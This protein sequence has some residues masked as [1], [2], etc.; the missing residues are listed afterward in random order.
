MKASVIIPALNEAQTIADVVK[1]AKAAPG[2]REVIVVSDGSR[3]GTGVAAQRAGADVV[4]ELP[5]R[6]GKG[7]AVMTGVDRARGEVVIMLDGD[8]IGLQPQH[9]E[10]LLDPLLRDGTDM[11]VGVFRRDLMQAVLPLYSGQR[12]VRRDLLLRQPGLRNVGFGLERTLA[13]IARRERWCIRRIE[14]TEVSHRLK[15]EK[16]GLVRGYQA[17]LR[18]AEE[19]FGRRPQVRRRTGPRALAALVVLLMVHGLSGVFVRQSSA[20]HLPPMPA[21]TSADRIMLVVAHSDDEVIAA[22]GYLAAALEAGGQVTVVILTN[23]DGNK[24]SA[25]VVTRRLRP[26]QKDFIREGQIRQQESIAAL[27]RLG[28]PPGRVIFMGFPDRGLQMLLAT[29]WSKL[30][31]YTSPFTKVSSPPYPGVYRS[32]SR[33]AGED[34]LENLVEIMHTVQPTLLLTHS[35]LDEHPDHKATYAFVAQV[36][37]RT[38]NRSFGRQPTLYTFLI[39]ADDFPRPLRYAPQSVLMPPSRLLESGEWRSFS[40][41][42]A[43]AERKREAA[44]AYRSQYESPYL[45]LLLNSFIRRNELFLAELP[46]A[47]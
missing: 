42:S 3:D 2:V 8:L 47:D 21:P 25:A 44:Q 22:G 4:I 34:L 45:R 10:R 36:M 14:W 20:A 39:H 29:H 38:A 43:Q 5:R 9:V 37:K 30:H 16:Y 12:A 7:G 40:L 28:L 18:M 46:P 17:K 26:K 6:V 13:S 19:L 24:F 33:Y 23:G 1:A 41:T 32:T 35:A 31:P 11:V 15:E 27:S